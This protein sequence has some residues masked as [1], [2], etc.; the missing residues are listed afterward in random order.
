MLPQIQQM[1]NSRNLALQ[2][3]QQQQWEQI[4]RRQQATPRPV[5]NMDNKDRPMVEVKV[6][7]PSDFPMDHNAFNNMNSR[8]P[9]LQQYR[10]QQLAAMAQNNNAFRTVSSLQMPQIQ[11]P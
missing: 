1:L 10:Q 8:Y 2:Q 4:K 7:N 11:S 3:Q 9:Q 5:M 6:E